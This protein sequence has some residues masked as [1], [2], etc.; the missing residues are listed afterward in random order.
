MGTR[1]PPLSSTA[2]LSSQ[3]LDY[4]SLR[5]PS[6]LRAEKQSH[7]S[8]YHNLTTVL[9]FADE[10][11]HFWWTETASIIGKLMESA[12]YD[13]D[14]QRF[15][16]LLYHARIVAALGPKPKPGS[17]AAPWESF[18]TD[19]H[20]PIE[21]SW[22]LGANLSVVRFSIEP[23][24]PLAGTS[25]DPFNQRRAIELLEQ[26]NK[27]SSD[28]D[29]QW[30]NHF[31]KRFLVEDHKTETV[32]GKLPANEHSSQLFVAFDL[33]N[34]KA[35]TKAYIFPILKAVERGISPLDL[36]SQAIRQLDTPTISVSPAWAVV[37]DFIRSCPVESR[38]KTEFV[39]VDCVEPK[40]SRI[41]V[42][43]RTQHMALEKVKDV[44]T[45]GG[46]LNDRT[47]QTALRMLEELWRL[48]LNL[49][50]NVRDSDELRPRDGNSAGHRT[51]GLLFNF[52]MRPGT[53]LPE[54]KVYIPVRHYARSDLD[55]ARGLTSFFR[56]R[57][58]TSLA[59]MYTT[60]LK[61]MFPHHP[62]AETTGTHTYIVFAYKKKT[63]VYLTAYYNP[64]VYPDRSLISA[65]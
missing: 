14:S 9:H 39:A 43:I 48:V 59:R 41:K 20:T 4:V 16:L 10:D 40:E 34:G 37:E 5:P 18:M 54:P 44:F 29:L 13:V 22:N 24:G 64:Q 27:L 51:S 38:P 42:Y 53:P 52:E 36:V 35:T 50:D 58:W 65:G 62:L 17:S 30:F 8:V 19:D 7:N 60:N 26:A 63:G 45:L 31:R 25:V 12:G 6:A 21:I 46:R 11:Q 28:V 56:R 3:A 23:V 33:D 49:P 61:E 32:L 57:G 47:T 2:H 1:T 55:I 15:Y